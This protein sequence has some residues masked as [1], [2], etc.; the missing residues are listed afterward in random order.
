MRPYKDKS[1][2]RRLEFVKKCMSLHEK[3]GLG[4]HE[5]K[6]FVEDLEQAYNNGDVIKMYQM[7]TD[8]E[9]RKAI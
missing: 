3:F 6:A 1:V 5:D 7:L 9:N 2:K 4:E 8:W